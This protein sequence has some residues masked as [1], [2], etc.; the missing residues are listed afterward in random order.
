M[1]RGRVSQ[2]IDRC[3]RARAEASRLRCKGESSTDL[4]AYL[5]P[6]D[7][8]ER[9]RKFWGR[10]HFAV[11]IDDMPGDGIIFRSHNEVAKR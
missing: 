1:D 5:E 8:K 10:H 3:K 2:F 9:W 11:P 4:N 7:I 6:Q